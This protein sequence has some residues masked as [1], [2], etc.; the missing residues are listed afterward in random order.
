[1]FNIPMNSKAALDLNSLSSSSPAPVQPQQTFN[2]QPATPPQQS[3]S[4]PAFN[5]QPSTPPQQ[6]FSQPQATPAAPRPSGGGVILKKG[7]KTS[8]SKIN[9]AL[10]NIR[11]GLGWDVG[12]NTS[13]DLD[14]EIFL[15]GAN[16]K[17]IGDDWFVFYGQ[18]TSP[19]GA[20]VHHGDNKTGIG[21][22]DDEIIDINLSQLNPQVEKI[23]FVVTINEAKENGYNFGQIKNAYIRIIDNS[24]GKELVRFD[25]S[26]YYK[27]V[28]SMVIGELYLKGGEWR[29]NP[30]GMGTGDDLEGLCIRYGV[31]VAG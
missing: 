17:V 5:Q 13:Y 1:M 21:E 22:G 7:Q 25:L 10:N 30:V 8:L 2:Q 16:E 31:N 14:S 23:V 28:V 15:L 4:Q 26:E 19:D 12:S 20:V 27:E 29:F 9:P 11:V 18:L 24:N 6:N 3:F